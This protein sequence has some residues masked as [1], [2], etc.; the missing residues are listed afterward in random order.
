MEKIL[1]IQT[2]SIGDVV[3]STSL[4]ESIHKAYPQAEIDVLVKKPLEGLFFDHPFIRK[5]FVWDKSNHKYKNL[6]INIFLIQEEKYSHVFNLQ[7]F[8][9]TGLICVFSKAK[10]KVGFSKNP[11]SLLFTHRVKHIINN[12]EFYHEIDRNFALAERFI[13][14]DFKSLP[15]LYPN[16]QNNAKMSEYKRGI[17]Y[18]ISP[19][20]LWPTKAFHKEGWIELLKRV[21]KDSTIYLLGSKN[22]IELCEEIKQ[23]I[24]HPSI[25]NLSGK[26]SFLD[27]CS[28]MKDARMNFTNDSAPLHFA[29]SVNAPITAIFCSTIEGFGFTPL[30]K[31]SLVI[32]SN[33]NL[34]C[35]PCGIHGHKVCPKKHFLCSKSINIDELVSRL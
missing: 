10:N 9:S 35:K 23:E 21:D 3:L 18:T 33:M 5:I 19:A 13:S 1:I 2:A 16:S 27:T 6:L 32:K 7:R 24:N 14:K 8:F 34:D 12:M 15:R 11:L 22:D 28:L 30:S 17:Y 31:D 20:S 26:L 4:L 29:S 25:L